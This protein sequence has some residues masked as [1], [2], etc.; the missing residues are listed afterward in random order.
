MNPKRSNTIIALVVLVIV[1]IGLITY[2]SFYKPVDNGTSS[3]NHTNVPGRTSFVASSSPKSYQTTTTPLSITNVH[4]N[5]T[6]IMINKDETVLVTARVEGS[7]SAPTN[8]RLWDVSGNKNAVILATLYD[9]GLNGDQTAQDHIYSARI[10]IHKTQPGYLELRVSAN[11][12]GSSKKVESRVLT[13]QIK[14]SLGVMNT[15]RD[16]WAENDG[17][18]GVMLCWSPPSSVY[19]QSTHIVVY[20]SSSNQKTWTTAFSLPLGATLPTCVYDKV[21]GTTVEL[22]YKASLLNASDTVM[23]TFTPLD[24]PKTI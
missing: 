21:D 10:I 15:S 17:K 22:H 3:I 23:Y 1:V 13:I 5:P 18:T 16:F 7:L 19:S 12:Q 8:V 4:A 2:F 14:K 6:A 20:R 9:N 24:V 11:H